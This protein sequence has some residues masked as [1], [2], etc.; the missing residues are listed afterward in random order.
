MRPYGVTALGIFFA[1]GA[2]ISSLSAAREAFTGL[3][4]W[5]VLLLSFVS[6]M[7][8]G[9]AVGFWRRRRW[10]YWLGVGLLLVNLIADIANVA[11]GIEPRAAVGIPIVVALLF[12]LSR[13]R[14]CTSF[15]VT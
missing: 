11:L 4:G 8:V 3:G 12:Y 10:G 9:V 2:L 5:V 7:R 14:V 1:A 15:L 6:C 13:P